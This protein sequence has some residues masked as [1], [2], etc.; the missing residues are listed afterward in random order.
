[1]VSPWASG[2]LPLHKPFHLVQKI[3]ETL[4]GVDSISLDILGRDH[5]A[6]TYFLVHARQPSPI[7][8]Y[9]NFVVDCREPLRMA[10]VSAS[11]PSGRLEPETPFA[12]PP[13]RTGQLDLE[14][15]NFVPVHVLDGTRF[16]AEFAC[17]ASSQPGRAA[18]LAARLVETG[19]PPDTASLYCDMQ[20][21][22]GSMLRRG[23]EVRYSVAEDVVAV[24]GQWLSSGFVTDDEIV[25]GA[26]AQ[27]RVS[28]RG[29]GARLV[30]D[31][32]AVLFTGECSVRPPA[33]R[34]ADGTAGR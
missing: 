17:G 4:V 24:N 18:Q 2:Q 21:D 28:R 32:G 22:S 5:V 29:G 1:M 19:G 27:W 23:V 10:T 13:R 34:P 15:L 11:M 9:A 14:K 30:R 8:G 12:Q 20:S 16:V 26:G 31:N 7:I 33:A 6:G 3:D 25:F